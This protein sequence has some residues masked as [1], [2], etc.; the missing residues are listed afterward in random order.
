MFQYMNSGKRRDKI[1]AP[2]FIKNVHN[3]QIKTIMKLDI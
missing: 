1:D 3:K 2:Q